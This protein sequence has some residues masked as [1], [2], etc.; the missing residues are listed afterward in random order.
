[1]VAG[2]SNPVGIGVQLSSVVNIGAVVNFIRQAI[3]VAVGGGAVAVVA[4]EVENGAGASGAI[5]I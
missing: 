5:D 1:M 2:L 4:Y 3:A